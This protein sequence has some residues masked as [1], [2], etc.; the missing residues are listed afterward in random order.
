[1]HSGGLCFLVE[2]ARSLYCHGRL[3]GEL[4][5]GQVSF[6]DAVAEGVDDNSEGVAVIVV[7]T[8]GRGERDLLLIP[9]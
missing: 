8:K 5:P 7:D 1:M 2:I 6:I 9:L 4:Q 3:Y